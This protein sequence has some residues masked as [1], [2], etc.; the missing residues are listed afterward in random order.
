[1]RATATTST[2]H[3]LSIWTKQDGSNM[4]HLDIDGDVRTMMDI[5]DAEI[6]AFAAAMG[7]RVD[8]TTLGKTWIRVVEVAL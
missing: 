7:Y 3:V 1:M 6:E 5:P 8:W 4:P 2:G